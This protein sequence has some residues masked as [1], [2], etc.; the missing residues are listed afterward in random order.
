MYI[1]TYKYFTDEEFTINVEAKNKEA[2]KAKFQF[3][4]PF[5]TIISCV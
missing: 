1:I 3:L 5:A 4:H 2:A